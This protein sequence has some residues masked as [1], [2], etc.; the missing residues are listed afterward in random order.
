[1]AAMRAYQRW[2][3]DA[4]GWSDIGYHIVIFPSG[5]VYLARSW[6]SYGA[7]AYNGNHM[8]GIS[9]AGDYEKHRPTK[10]A[11]ASLKKVMAEYGITSLVGHYKVPGNSTGCPGRY[12]KEALGV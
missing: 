6:N 9:I 2:H 12:L 5:H 10:E 11:L 1:M 4:N 7:H 8:A 3:M